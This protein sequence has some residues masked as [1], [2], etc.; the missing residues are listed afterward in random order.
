MGTTAFNFTCQLNDRCECLP[1]EAGCV[2]GFI[3]PAGYYGARCLF[4]PAYNLTVNETDATIFMLNSAVPVSLPQG[5]TVL[6]VWLLL[7]SLNFIF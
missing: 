1:D 6:G 3:C 4:D 5:G 7:R 2:G